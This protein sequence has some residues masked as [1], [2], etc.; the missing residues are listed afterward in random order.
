MKTENAKAKSKFAGTGRFTG[1]YD[2]SYPNHH[3]YMVMLNGDVNLYCATIEAALANVFEDADITYDLLVERE[4]ALHNYLLT[5]VIRRAED[6]YMAKLCNE[7][8]R[9][10]VNGE[11]IFYDGK[12]VASVKDY[13][14]YYIDCY[15]RLRHED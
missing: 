6:T 14:G 15:E 7:C 10:K 4:K 2:E 13:T 1:K 11:H 9:Y 5:H 3:R 8:P 12:A